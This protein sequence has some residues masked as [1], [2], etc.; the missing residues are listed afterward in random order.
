MEVMTTEE[1]LAMPTQAEW[2]HEL[3]SGWPGPDGSSSSTDHMMGVRIGISDP[4][5]NHH[6]YPANLH[7]YRYHMGRK[8]GL[9]SRYRQLADVEYRERCI[10]YIDRRLDGK[11]FTG[12]GIIRAWARYYALR[13]FGWRAWQSE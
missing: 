8:Y 2:Q 11:I 4:G 7:D 1:F 10:E 13:L 5:Y 3:N 12:L 9:P 6:K